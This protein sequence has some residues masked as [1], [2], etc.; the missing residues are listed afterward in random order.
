LQSNWLTSTETEG[1]I[2]SKYGFQSSITEESGTIEAAY[3]ENVIESERKLDLEYVH[4]E[5]PILTESQA[6]SRVDALG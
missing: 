3:P 2:G 6:L 4:E 5:A 1:T